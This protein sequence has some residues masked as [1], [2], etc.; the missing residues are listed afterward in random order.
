M[1]S[2]GCIASPAA[3]VNITV[4]PKPDAPEL[5]S[6]GNKT[7]VK[8]TQLKFKAKATDPDAGQTLS[9]SLIGAPA[10]AKINATNRCI[11]MDTHCCRQFHF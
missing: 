10:G 5:A 6:I 9:Y 3:V 11:H 8:N 4:V 2:T 7:V 1:V